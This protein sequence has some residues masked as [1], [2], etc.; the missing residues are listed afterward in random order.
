MQAAHVVIIAVNTPAKAADPSPGALEAR[1]C[2]TNMEAFFSV[3]RAIADSISHELRL[4]GRSHKIIIE[5]STVP[6][7]TATA[8]EE[9]LCCH[10]GIDGEKLRDHVTVV[11][12]PEFLAEGSAINDLVNPQRVVVGTQNDL[13]FAIV[14]QL[15]QG[16]LGSNEVK[17]IRTHDTGSSELGKLVCNAMLAQRVSSINSITALCEMTPSCDISD[18]RRIVESDN[19]IG[20]KFLQC[21]LGFGGSCFEKDIQSLVYILASNN[22]AESAIY[23][24]GVLDIN[25]RQKAR[26]AEVVSKNE[27]PGATLAIFGLS[28][29]KDTSDTRNTPVAFIVSTLL[30]L[31]FNLRL[32]DP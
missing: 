1:G 30:A 21:S 22:M 25:Q 31:G 24:Q 18:V 5:K 15:V 8:M 10:L 12:M 23:W 27:L 14:N 13:A 4:E 20:G 29:K 26:L 19:R 32:H 9:Q 7:G 3:V 6:L 11:N 17:V 28:Y 16:S 2:P